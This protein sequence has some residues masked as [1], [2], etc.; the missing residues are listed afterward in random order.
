MAANGPH[1]NHEG[2][3]LSF[4]Q[5]P[6]PQPGDDGD[7]IGGHDDDDRS[8]ISAITM[9]TEWNTVSP[10]SSARMHG[11]GHGHGVGHGVG[12]GHDRGDGNAALR[13]GDNVNVSDDP[14]SAL[15]AAAAAAAASSSNA[16]AGGSSSK[17]SRI[18][19]GADY[20][21]MH[22][23]MGINITVPD[24]INNSKKNSI[25]R[26][27]MTANA[28]ANVGA[29]TAAAGAAAGAGGAGPTTGRRRS[30]SLLRD[31]IGAGVGG[32]DGSGAHPLWGGGGGGVLGAGAA[33][34]AAA[35]QKQKLQ[36][37]TAATAIGAASYM[38]K[39]SGVGTG[40][41]TAGI[42]RRAKSADR[43]MA[44]GR[45]DRERD[46][47][48]NRDRDR[49]RD[50][51][52]RRSSITGGAAAG[53]GTKIG[54]T[55]ATAAA[56][57]AAARLQSAA[58]IASRSARQARQD[59]Q[60]R[61][62][63]KQSDDIMAAASTLGLRVG[64]ST[65]VGA[66][67]G[68]RA[69]TTA[70]KR[71]VSSSTS[72]DNSM[73][74]FA[75]AHKRE[76]GSGGNAAPSDELDLL[77]QSMYANKDRSNNNTDYYDKDDLYGSSSSKMD[78]IGADL[79]EFG[80]GGNKAKTRA[81]PSNR[82]NKTKDSKTKNIASP[83]VPSYA[84]RDDMMD[85]SS[86]KM[87]LIGADL[88]DTLNVGRRGS[89]AKIKPKT[90]E[91]AKNKAKDANVTTTKDKPRDRSRDRSNVAGGD[92]GGRNRDRSK[93]RSSLVV[94]GGK[95]R[96]RSRDRSNMIAGG[97]KVRDRSRDRSKAV[98]DDNREGSSD[99]RATSRGRETAATVSAGP[100]A[101]ATM[102]TAIA[103]AAAKDGNNKND[104]SMSMNAFS[105]MFSI[106]STGRQGS[107]RTGND[108]GGTTTD[109][110]DSSSM[111]DVGALPPAAA[112]AAAAIAA[113]A[114]SEPLAAQDEVGIGMSGFLTTA[115]GTATAASAALNNSQVL[116][117]STQS[118]ASFTSSKFPTVAT[119]TKHG[120]VKTT[121][122]D[123]SLSSSTSNFSFRL[124]KQQQ[125]PGK[126][127]RHVADDAIM[128]DE[129]V[130]S[131]EAAN[132]SSP[133]FEALADGSNND[134]S[135]IPSRE[136]RATRRLTSDTDIALAGEDDPRRRSS[137]GESAWDSV[138]RRVEEILA[139]DEEDVALAAA[140]ETPLENR[141]SG[142]DVAAA[143]TSDSNDKNGGEGIAGS[144][145]PVI[146]EAPVQY[147]QKMA[148]PAEEGGGNNKP[149]DR[150]PSGGSGTSGA[151]RSRGSLTV[152]MAALGLDQ[153][154]SA[155]PEQTDA[156]D[157]DVGGADR[158][159]ATKPGAV[160]DRNPAPSAYHY[161]AQAQRQQPQQQGT[162]TAPT[163]TV[164]RPPPIDRRSA[165]RGLA[166]TRSRS[167][168]DVLGAMREQEVERVAPQTEGGDEP[169]QH[170]SLAL[171]DSV[172]LDAV[173]ALTAAG[174]VT[175]ASTS[176]STAAAAQFLEEQRAAM[177]RFSSQR[178]EN[179]Q[180]HTGDSGSNSRPYWRDVGVADVSSSD[181]FNTDM[182]TA[183][184][185]HPNR[186]L[187]EI[188]PGRFEFLRGS[189]ETWTAIKSNN[190]AA[191]K[192]T[193][194]GTELRC[195][196]DA[197]M[198]VCPGEFACVSRSVNL[199]VHLLMK[200]MN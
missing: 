177:E 187:I 165:G 130:P 39:G 81:K 123:A 3:I 200:N 96:D 141:R 198:V 8:I 151:E 152:A 173:L 30:T 147:K 61:Q 89:K 71:N 168:A 60:D 93:D 50:R 36:P 128:E 132:M 163:T 199:I 85:D 107:N 183:G 149:L 64:P 33:A 195:V 185:N 116:Q 98:G 192:C 20:G 194:C 169:D 119:S 92:G 104:A 190:Y 137:G 35:K 14:S 22:A 41:G 10:R 88:E 120:F 83:A 18:D 108:T 197:D 68:T 48:R 111:F 45:A 142:A 51:S 178:M 136:F 57:A 180:E 16:G 99:N 86:S 76:A 84:N 78:L 66:G 176:Q 87:D 113:K 82:D 191:I 179:A 38:M 160:Y 43:A 138:D 148:P 196:A 157:D 53:K 129:V 181:G 164:S 67:T 139:K 158:N 170:S 24:R 32:R 54:T 69:T 26:Q 59:R 154:D 97:G 117:D 159:P 40:V 109:H 124:Q 63:D 161:Q 105:N 31:R 5:Y 58:A 42:N 188:S 110:D 143:G 62:A 135:G 75:T 172:D 23:A 106:S 115:T 103:D 184:V 153:S 90:K 166:P 1:V 37:K 46:R 56:A 74:G 186:P 134:N 102:S 140:V 7:G 72:G 4:P 126:G 144:G 133:I 34:A 17:S 100:A 114:T 193:I 52:R 27:Q 73:H 6:N 189:E 15:G 101:A 155:L 175:E 11:H 65:G 118:F 91:K 150:R 70:A 167:R 94:G 21:A 121:G 112:A 9:G 131:E 125:G 47:D 174:G 146:Q 2:E 122:L 19:L 49:D 171:S 25:R 182:T 29:G 80:R 95:N 127:G 79:E 145:L 162:T 13:S 156:G 28:N 77:Q 55:D 12:V 44:V